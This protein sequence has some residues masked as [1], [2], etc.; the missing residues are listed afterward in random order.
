MGDKDDN[1]KGNVLEKARKSGIQKTELEINRSKGKA[2]VLK[3]RYLM[4]FEKE[5]LYREANF[6]TD[7]FYS[8]RKLEVGSL[9]ESHLRE[10]EGELNRRI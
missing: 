5:V 6:S 1:W 3:R 10:W 9:S 2:S 8:L 4:I 7:Y